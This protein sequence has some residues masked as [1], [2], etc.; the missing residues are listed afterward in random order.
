MVPQALDGGGVDHGEQEGP[1][2]AALHVEQQLAAFHQRGQQERL[3]LGQG[4]KLLVQ[5]AHEAHELRVV[6]VAQK[7]GH[8][9]EERSRARE[10][11]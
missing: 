6:W 8:V 10:D 7:P 4:L 2:R 5:P 11:V 3:P 1:L 9:L